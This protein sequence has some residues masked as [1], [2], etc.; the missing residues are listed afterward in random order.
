MPRPGSSVLLEMRAGRG[1]WLGPS[2]AGLSDL[3]LHPAEVELDLRRYRIPP[4]PGRPRGPAHCEA[5]T[6][7]TALAYGR[8]LLAPSDLTADLD[9]PLYQE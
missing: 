3:Q 6:L 9:W 4:A 1:R 7:L 5:L 2:A 8:T